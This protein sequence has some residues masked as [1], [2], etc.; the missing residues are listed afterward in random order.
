MM[1]TA[2]TGVGCFE[3]R[4]RFYREVDRASLCR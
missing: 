2:L 4:A 3:A 1:P